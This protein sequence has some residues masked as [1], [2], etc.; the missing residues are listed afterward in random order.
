MREE[1]VPAQQPETQQEARLPDPD[2]QARRPRGDHPPASQGTSRPVGL[3]WRVRDRAT[4]RAL[5][6][7]RRIRRGVLTMT[8][9]ATRAGD[10]PSVAFAVGRSVGNA[11]AR[12]RLR[13]RLRAVCR[14]HAG[15]LEPG[16]AYL[17]GASPA[18]AHASFAELDDTVR[19]LI[20]RSRRQP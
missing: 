1:D 16:H 4:F 9:V 18:A 10:P 11:V 7:S 15:E 6:S 17:L 3:I 19:E 8:R 5:A 2:A 12:N 13:R 20:A 14:A